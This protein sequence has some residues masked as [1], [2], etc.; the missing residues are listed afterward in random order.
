MVILQFSANETSTTASARGIAAW[1]Q[2]LSLK[3]TYSLVVGIA[4]FPGV[5][6]LCVN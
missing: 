1:H 4:V 5:I 3:Q 6:V 2:Q